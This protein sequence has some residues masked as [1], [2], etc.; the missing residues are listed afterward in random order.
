MSAATARR[1]VFDDKEDGENGRAAGPLGCSPGQRWDPR[2]VGTPCALTRGPRSGD[3]RWEGV[4][5]SRF[6]RNSLPVPA[7]PRAPRAP[8]APESSGG[9]AGRAGRLAL[10][11][12]GRRSER[13]GLR[14]EAP[15]LARARFPFSFAA[16]CAG[17]VFT[18]HRSVL[19]FLREMP[20][21]QVARGPGPRRSQCG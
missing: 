9:A 11:R 17:S 19:S 13:L 8:A 7:V 18:P 16:R 4:G 2:R 21:P 20:A 3:F 14:R 6:P 15:A 12:E 10:R 1:P 5:A